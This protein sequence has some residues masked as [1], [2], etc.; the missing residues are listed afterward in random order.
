M[1]D[2][3]HESRTAFSMRRRRERLLP[4]LLFAATLVV[5]SLL[6]FL[7]VPTTD[8]ALDGTLSAVGFV[9]PVQQP[10]GQ[11]L[12][13]I[14]VGAAGLTGL[15][16]SDVA[17]PNGSGVSAIRIAA[18]GARGGKGVLPG[19]I[20]LDRLVVPEGTEV[21][22]SRTDVP[23]QFRISLRSPKPVPVT[24]HADMIGPVAFA[25]AGEPATRATLHA[26]R[27]V[28][29]TSTTGALDLDVA[30][31]S[32]APVPR[33]QQ[34][35]ARDLKLYRVEDERDTPRPVAIPV[36][37]ILSGSIRFESLDGGEQPLRRGEI[38]RFERASGTILTLE[39]QDAGVGLMFQGE[40]SGMRLGAGDHSRSLMP[41]LLQWLRQRHGLSLL[42]GSALYLFGLSMALRRWWQKTE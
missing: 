9:S 15:Q 38:L 4:A 7:H 33:W 10:L 20:T 22:L 36:S 2:E 16:L 24:A 28:E 5:V 30:L 1:R 34:L 39:L 3:E 21:W 14:A 18:E 26:P 23:R 11:P 35:A 25:P 40:V 32:G 17:R 29:F 19:S 31:A 27:P 41:T 12:E 13:V 6:L 37:S 8:I 42:W